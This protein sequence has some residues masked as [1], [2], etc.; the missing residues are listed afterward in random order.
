M[1]TVKARRASLR[2]FLESHASGE[3]PGLESDDLWH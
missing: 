1:A 3:L 2:K